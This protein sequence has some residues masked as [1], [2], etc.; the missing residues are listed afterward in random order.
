MNDPT[1][2]ETSIKDEEEDTENEEMMMSLDEAYS[3]YIDDAGFNGLYLDDNIIV[4]KISV[5][6]EKHLYCLIAWLTAVSK[7]AKKSEIKNESVLYNNLTMLQAI[8]SIEG[9]FSYA[10]QNPLI[11][12]NYTSTEIVNLYETSQNLLPK[13][14]ERLMVSAVLRTLFNPKI[15]DYYLD[16]LICVIENLDVSNKYP[17][18]INLLSEMK[19]FYD[20][21]GCA[22]DAFAGYRSNVNVIDNVIQE[23]KEL[24]DSIDKRNDIFESQGQVRRLREAMLSDEKSVLRKCLNIVAENDVSQFKYVR[25][26]MEDKFIRNNRSLTIENID[27]SK[28]DAFIDDYWDKARDMIISEGRHIARP[29]DKIKGSKR[30]NDN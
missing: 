2:E 7:I 4:E 17:M 5:F 3:G 19:K 1:K 11:D 28:I 20:N 22:I 21:T 12:C 18:L 24:C 8:Q 23:A 30:T 16:D 15:Q 10:Y 13:Y 29:H 9:A 27:V 26:T 14:S 25:S 6:D